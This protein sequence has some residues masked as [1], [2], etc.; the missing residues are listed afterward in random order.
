MCLFGAAEV[1]LRDAMRA[2]EPDARLEQL[3]RSAL[4][5]K[6]PQ[7]AGECR[8]R[9]SA[10]GHASLTQ[11]TN[12]F[13]TGRYPGRGGR[14]I[15]GQ[16]HNA[17][18]SPDACRYAESREHEESADGAHRRLALGAAPASL[19]VP[20]ARAPPATRVRPFS[21]RAGDGDDDASART[22]AATQRPAD[23]ESQSDGG[24]FT[25][26]DARGRARMVDVGDKPVTARAAEAECSLL[27]GARL[28]RLL[29]DA[30]LPKG[31]AL[32]V[33][34]VAGALAAKRTAELIPLC[35]PL[36][37]ECARVRV[38]LP[39]GDAGRGGALR[40]HC[41]VRVTARTGAEMEALTGCAVAALTLYDMC[42]S[43]DRGMRITDLRVVRKSGGRS[44]EWPR[45]PE[46]ASPAAAPADASA[47]RE[48]YAP[49]NFPYF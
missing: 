18:R 40:V 17:F 46:P 32:T 23:D 21:T 3:V 1:S 24:A 48:I 33:A 14:S 27:V 6:L 16:I 2:G 25:H 22:P 49:T 39:A 26:L 12:V 31:D 7:H 42:K 13:L 8:R 41:E 10:A 19:G 36:P 47:D 11:N 43:V 20:L 29:R 4:R 15:L 30:R 9:A 34:Q 37:L 35:H 38:E 44:G 5:R 45:S 28:L